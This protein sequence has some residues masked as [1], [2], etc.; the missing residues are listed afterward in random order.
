MNRISPFIAVALAAGITACGPT[1]PSSAWFGIDQPR[2]LTDPPVLS[3]PPQT[4]AAIVPADD[5]EEP[6]FDGEAIY[7]DLETIV[8]FADEMEASG[9]QF[10]GR[11]AGLPSQAATAEWVA[12]Q[13]RDAGLQDV[14]VQTIEATSSMWLPQ[15]WEVRLIADPA[16]GENS[17]DLVLQS[18]VPAS[19]SELDEPITAPLVF[20]GE[21]GN[22]LDVDVAGKIAI[23]HARPTTGAYSERTRMRESAQA[24]IDAGAVAVINWIEQSGN[25]HVYDFGRCG[26]VCFNIGGDDGAFLAAVLELA[27]ETP[28]TAQLSLDAGMVEGLSASN[29][30][31]IVPGDSEE[32]IVVNAHN[33][34]WFDGAGDN[35][36]GQAVQLALAR[37]YARPENRP[38]RTLIFVSS[39]GHHSA[40]LN[41][42]RAA[43]EMNPDLLEDAILVLN[44]EHVA[45]Y[46]VRTDPWRVDPT[47]EPKSMGVSN[48]APLLTEAIETGAERYGYTWDTLDESVP[49]DLGGY[50]SLG[51]AR[52]QGIHSGP[53]YHTSGDVTQS[54]SIEGLERAARFYRYFIDAVAE[55]PAGEVNPR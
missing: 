19:Y 36:D 32:T 49:G 38:A 47:E 13:Y 44:L 34:S 40:G 54:I 46:Q 37:H 9:A 10:W 2:G 15:S 3:D 25:M 17:E 4:E 20:T 48:M 7:A 39:A 12:E 24:L 18:A 41:G 14:E 11:I 55:A 52:V 51:V 43:V 21:A 42:P 16:F 45:Q 50:G 26:G 28:V 33:D 30:V 23:Q 1:L 31:G 22:P 35:G 5:P 29:V 27:G 53:L 6:A 8:G